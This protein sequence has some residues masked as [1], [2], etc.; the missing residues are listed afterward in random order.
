MKLGIKFELNKELD[1]EMAFVFVNM[2]NKVGGVDFSKNVT[3]FHPEL[4]SVKDLDR[5]E[6]I[7][8]IGEYMDKYYEDN[9]NDL[10]KQKLDFQSDWEKTENEFVGHLNKIFK[11]PFKPEGEW[12]GYLSVINCNPRFLKNKTF[13]VFYK[14]KNVKEVA[15]HE[16]LHFFFYDYA[17]K[18]FPEI[19]E[20]LDTN[21]GTFWKLAELFNDVIQ[22]LPDFIERRD[23]FGYPDHEKYRDYLSVLWSKNPDIDVW[24]PE[25]FKYLS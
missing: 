23:V 20:K 18:K 3:N 9:I 8:I 5:N 21:T 2:T 16:I 10:E 14:H 15:I 22:A 19:F 4:E 6:Q 7:K 11:N 13:Q 1:K 12:T 17:I 24:I 25:A